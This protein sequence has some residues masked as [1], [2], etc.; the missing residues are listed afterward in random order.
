MTDLLDLQQLASQT[1]HQLDPLVP[2]QPCPRSPWNPQNQQD[3]QKPDPQ[4][5][6]LL[7]DH[8]Q[9]ERPHSLDLLLLVIHLSLVLQELEASPEL[10]QLVKLAPLEAQLVL[11]VPLVS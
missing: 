6:Q 5:F 4:A 10:V 8:L 2:V 7:M 9:L 11:E 3:P 1:S